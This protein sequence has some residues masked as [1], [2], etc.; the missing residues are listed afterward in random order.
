MAAWRPLTCRFPLFLSAPR[1]RHGGGGLAAGGGHCTRAPRV[2]VVVVVVAFVVV[3]VIILPAHYV[4]IDRFLFL[5]PAPWLLYF[6][7]RRCRRHPPLA[8][9]PPIATVCIDPP[10]ACRR[11]TVLR[12]PRACASRPRAV[13]RLPRPAAVVLVGA[14]PTL[15][16]RSLHGSLHAAWPPPP[17]P[18]PRR[19][20]VQARGADA[21]APAAALPC[22]A[23]I[24]YC[25]PGPPCVLRAV[26]RAGVRAHTPL[27]ALPTCP[28]YECP[29]ARRGAVSPRWRVALRSG[30]RR[31]PRRAHRRARPP[32]TT[33][34]PVA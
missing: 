31:F 28:P 27:P 12:A 5:R 30:G 29:G 15:R 25:T 33:G 1:S 24:A 32:C 6:Q 22:P 7:A 34:R 8:A 13:R 26:P 2:P 23:S 11:H 9:C 14:S 3:M 17:H 21:R 4:T 16:K 20:G 19:R 10:A 18:T